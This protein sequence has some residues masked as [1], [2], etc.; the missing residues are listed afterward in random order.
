MSKQENSNQNSQKP[1]EHS[2]Q[3]LKKNRFFMILQFVLLF[4]IAFFVFTAFK[5]YN[6]IDN[7]IVEKRQVPYEV[8][9][10]FTARKVANDLTNGLFYQ[11]FLNGYLYL[12]SD[13][14]A[15]QKGVYEIDGKKTLKQ[16]LQ[17]MVN[18]NVL[19]QNPMT[20]TVVEGMTFNQVLKRIESKSLQNADLTTNIYPLNATSLDKLDK[21]YAFIEEVLTNKDLISLYPSNLSSLEGLLL[22]ATYPYFKDDN[23]LTVL[24]HAINKMAE[25]LAA[26]KADK[27]NAKCG[28]KNAYE[29]LILASL[30]EKESSLPEERSL[31]AGV[32]CNRLNKGMRLQTDPAVMYGVSPNFKGP[33]T[34]KHIDLDS[35]YNTY[36]RAGLPPTPIAMPSDKS[37]LAALNP[38]QTKAL[39]FVA[40]DV[41]P[42]MG[43]VFSNS[44]NEHNQ[45]VRVYKKK[46]REYKSKENE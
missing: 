5:A 24:A 13:L 37:I 9:T 11:I 32:F 27:G 4:L 19:K 8:Q 46:V 45:A 42:K 15:I 28:L 35:T 41:D 38:A 23:Y 16:I 26:N 30:I 1:Q 3:D 29:V 22:P 33:L 40:K 17:D 44:L 43:H 25:F 31:I 18:G 14:T 20:V 36:I 7:F 12:N 10:G 34:K 39:Y 6:N 2:T 21:P